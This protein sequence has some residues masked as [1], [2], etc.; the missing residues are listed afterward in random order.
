MRTAAHR[1]LLTLLLPLSACASQPPGPY[2]GDEQYLVF[3]VHPDA[4]AVA[5]AAQIEASGYPLARRVSGQS[6]TALGFVDE[7]GLPSKVRVVTSRGIALA[8]DPEPK[9]PLH[10]G[11]RFALL[12]A[13]SHDT[14]DAD[15][16][17]FEEV[18]VELQPESGQ[19][20]CILVY[21]VRDSGFVDE[22]PGKSYALLRTPDN[23]EGP[24]VDPQFCETEVEQT[25][26]TGDTQPAAG[27]SE[28]APPPA[29]EPGEAPAQTQS[30]P[31]SPVPD[32]DKP[33]G[34]P[35]TH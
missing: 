2:Y 18:F 25:A 17:G 1:R 28:P 20:T 19:G 29:A 12:E 11:A 3:G 5:L 14:A 13:P 22:V 7:Q 35:A 4:E 33:G 26:Q 6:F 9:D 27:T 30:S 32:D 10:E 21:R 15:G 16:D 31:P 24:F 23:A 8:L 34:S